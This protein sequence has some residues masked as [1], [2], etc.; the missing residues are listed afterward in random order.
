MNLEETRNLILESDEFV[1][2][3]FHKLQRLFE[4]KRVIRFH[5]QRE[6]ETGAD[7][8]AEHIY[9]MQI[10]F[11]YFWPLEDLD[12]NWNEARMLKMITWHD[13]EEIIT[14]DT[15]GYLKSASQ[16]EIEKEAQQLLLSEINDSLQQ[17]M[18]VA[19]A[20]YD[21]RQT[22]EA[23]FVKAIDKIEPVFQVYND[24]GKGLLQRLQTSRD[25]HDSIKAPYFLQFPTIKRFYDVMIEKMDQE[26][27]FIPVA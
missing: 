10:L 5:E 22:T 25:Q 23:K 24:A 21:D 3:E 12:Q 26:G 4:L 2:S 8:V 18:K 27:Y 14:G 11:Y 6:K 1:V 20:E 13:L 15:I 16:K 9:G 19:L 17:P 7:S